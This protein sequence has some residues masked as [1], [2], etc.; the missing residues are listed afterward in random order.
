MKITA[1]TL[2]QEF[3]INALTVVT[4]L[5]LVTNCFINELRLVCTYFF[6]LVVFFCILTQNVELLRKV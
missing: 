3:S 1:I 5:K 6:I 2:L 4:S